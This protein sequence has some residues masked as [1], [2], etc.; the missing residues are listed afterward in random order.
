VKN[1][2]QSKLLKTI[3]IDGKEVDKS[4]RG[5]VIDWYN[6]GTYKKRIQLED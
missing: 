2:F 6:D 3:S 1:D 4:Y 5:F